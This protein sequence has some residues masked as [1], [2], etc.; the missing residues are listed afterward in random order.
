MVNSIN[1]ACILYANSHP[2]IGW[3]RETACQFL[4]VRGPFC[5]DLISVLW[6][7]AHNLEH[8][9][10]ELGRHVLMKKIRHA[11]HKDHATAF[12]RNR[13]P[14]CIAID[15]YSSIPF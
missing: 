1:E 6:G 11:V 13:R 8:F 12:P 4:Q 5:E 7:R 14:Q 10:D 9:L 15:Y 2:N 3:P